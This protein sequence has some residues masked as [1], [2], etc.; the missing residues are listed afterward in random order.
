MMAIR[1]RF[2]G[3]CPPRLQN[4]NAGIMCDRHGIAILSDP[5]QELLQYFESVTS[6]T[7]I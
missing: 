1:G 7:E 6:P 5:E 4:F 2:W 3:E